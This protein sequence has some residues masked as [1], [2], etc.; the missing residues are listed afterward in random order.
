[1]FIIIIM[2]KADLGSSEIAE[3]LKK[4]IAARR[5]SVSRFGLIGGIAKL[6]LALLSL[7]GKVQF[8]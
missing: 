3:T 2:D 6:G 1:M 7:L 4:N 8:A 5:R